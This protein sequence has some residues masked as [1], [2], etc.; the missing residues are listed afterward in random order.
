MKPE[1]AEALLPLHHPGRDCDSKVQKA[2]KAAKCDDALC[3]KLEAQVEFDRQMIAVILS[4]KP[5]ENLKKKLRE[6]GGQCDKQKKSVARQVF[7]PVVLTA[8]LGVLLILGFVVWQG[9]ER[10]EKFK[11]RESVERMI[12]T[13]SKMSGIE[14]ETVST[15]GGTMGDWFYMRG[16]EGYTVPTEFASLPIVGSRVFRIDGHPV[17]Q[18]AVDKQNFVLC[19]FRVSDFDMNF[20]ETPEWKTIEY[21]EWVGGLRRK[22]ELGYLITLK[23]TDTDLQEILGTLPK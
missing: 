10:M 9:M 6:V 20:P 18:L 8:V 23:G 11:G 4:I 2:I 12:S 17:A 13:T 22:G 21:N 3:R 14:L 16:F 7:N 5:P 19:V 1:A 15:T